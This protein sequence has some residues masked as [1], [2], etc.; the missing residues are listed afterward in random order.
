MKRKQICIAG[1]EVGR[2]PTYGEG[3]EFVV[4]RIAASGYLH[5]DIDPMGLPCQ[6]SDKE[7]EIFLVDIT[8]ELLAA[9]NLEKFRE[10]RKKAGL[11]PADEPDLQPCAASLPETAKRSR[12]HLYRRHSAIKRPL[13]ENP[14]FPA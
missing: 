7:P 11:F 5:I 14:V 12:E 4:F 8:A 9:Q 2:L 1:D 13:E 6:R 10:L 3:E